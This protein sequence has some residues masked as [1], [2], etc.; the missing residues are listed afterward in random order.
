MLKFRIVAEFTL[1]RGGKF[2]VALMA[3]DTTLKVI[4]FAPSL[5]ILLFY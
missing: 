3:A 4:Y 5:L 2:S 1:L